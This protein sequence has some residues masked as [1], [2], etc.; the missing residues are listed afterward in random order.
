MTPKDSRTQPN[1]WIAWWSVFSRLWFPK[2][3]NGFAICSGRDR[4]D[5]LAPLHQ[6]LP[7][8]TKVSSLHSPVYY[9]WEESIIKGYALIGISGKKGKVLLDT[10]QR[11]RQMGGGILDLADAVRLVLGRYWLTDKWLKNADSSLFHIVLDVQTIEECQALRSA[12][13]LVF[14]LECRDLTIKNRWDD[15]ALSNFTFDAV[16]PV[17]KH[18]LSSALK[19][20]QKF[21][22]REVAIESESDSKSEV[23][24]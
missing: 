3:L 21:I 6:Y 11:I 2:K 8:K 16:F 14:Y 9:L 12:G 19:S 1:G 7:T 10:M 18:F 20:L 24:D 23:S 15:Y 17:H 22:V 5:D 13:L 4:Y